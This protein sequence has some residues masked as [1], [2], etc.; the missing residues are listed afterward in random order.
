LSV[1]SRYIR[2][3]TKFWQDEKVKALSHEARLLYLYVLTS[4]HS[5]MAGYY[6]LPKPY[7]AY[8][9]NWLPQQLDK[10]FG[11][12]VQQGLIKYC[13]QSD[14]VLIPNF[15]KYNPMQNKNQAKG[16][17]RRVGELPTNTLRGD[18][19]T[20]LERY[21]KP[22]MEW[23]AEGF[24]NTDTES[25]TESDTDTESES[26]T[27]A[28]AELKPDDDDDVKHFVSEV[29]KE[30]AIAFGYPPNQTQM[31]ML[32]SF[33][34]DGMAGELVLEALK[35]SAQN[36]AKGPTYTKAI[37]QSWLN[38]GAL[39]MVDVERLDGVLSRQ[40]PSNRTGETAAERLL[41]EEIEREQAE[42]DIID[43]AWSEGG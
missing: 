24:A 41:R 4:P 10:A 39:T 22:F 5:N 37:L 19:L 36:G 28:A 17:A 11:E 16:A 18:F 35:R 2:V 8:D 29:T 3:A 6:V 26:A 12:L 25:D 1:D 40:T 15:L 43:I 13:E 38:K 27:E 14:V 21:A 33:T 42:V 30:F 34:N 32:L 31:E 9:L 23:F 20:V 7:V